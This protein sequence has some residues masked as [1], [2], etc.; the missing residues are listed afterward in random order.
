MRD[1]ICT[2]SSI[3]TVT[4]RK[5]YVFVKF[6]RNVVSSSATRRGF[7]A[8]YV[9]YGKIMFIVGFFSL[10]IYNLAFISEQN[11][12]KMG[13]MPSIFNVCFY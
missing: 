10:N 7:V 11:V 4:T 12:R 9:I 6:H 1:K 5:N 2:N 8:G 3:V 13:T